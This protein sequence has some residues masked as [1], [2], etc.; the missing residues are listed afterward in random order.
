MLLI[1]THSAN[2]EATTALCIYS[3]SV[4]AMENEGKKQKKLNSS[5]AFVVSLAISLKNN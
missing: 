2:L 1:M 5:L 4:Y 3:L